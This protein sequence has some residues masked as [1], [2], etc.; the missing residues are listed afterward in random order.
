MLS[1]K[2]HVWCN[3]FAMFCPGFE[4]HVLN[5][6]DCSSTSCC[7][8]SWSTLPALPVDFYLKPAEELKTLW[9]WGGGRRK[10]GRVTLIQGDTSLQSHSPLMERRGP[11]LKTSSENLTS[12]T[13]EHALRD[14][15]GRTV[16]LMESLWLD[17]HLCQLTEPSYWLCCRLIFVSITINQGFKERLKLCRCR[18][19]LQQPEEE[20]EM[21]FQGICF[22]PL[23]P[24]G[25][26]NSDTSSMC[27]VKLR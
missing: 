11:F 24:H 15:A 8:Q 17:Q 22:L 23:R 16:C 26:Q 1:W 13:E 18:F 4:T 27:H 14:A 10:K 7:M 2:L 21:L 6:K 20:R 19:L 9:K 12:G 3:I 5:L 25:L